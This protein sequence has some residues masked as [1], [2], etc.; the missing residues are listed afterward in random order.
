[1][2][3]NPFSYFKEIDHRFCDLPTLSRSGW[4]NL[5]KLQRIRIFE[6]VAAQE[7]ARIARLDSA[8]FARF[9]GGD[10]VAVG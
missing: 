9:L 3:Y 2:M 1:M 6:N 10:I 7:L 4:D 5:E 8:H